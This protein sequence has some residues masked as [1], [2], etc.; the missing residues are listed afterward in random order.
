[1]MT[2]IAFG[3]GDPAKVTVVRGQ[4][5]TFRTA[6]SRVPGMARYVGMATRT[7][8]RAMR[9]MLKADRSRLDAQWRR[10]QRRRKRRVGC[11]SDSFRRFRR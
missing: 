7:I 11:D 2:S 9:G 3:F 5:M 10:R 1:M 6:N 8:D 4:L